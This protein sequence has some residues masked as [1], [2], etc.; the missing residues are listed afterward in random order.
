MKPKKGSSAVIF[1]NFRSAHR[2][3]FNFLEVLE[4]DKNSIVSIIP[5]NE[6][7]GK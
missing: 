1:R 3:R 2:D 5:I 6:L 7:V 4:N